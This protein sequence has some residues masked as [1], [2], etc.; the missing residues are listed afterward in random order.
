MVMG[1]GL[2]VTNERKKKKKLWELSNEGQIDNGLWKKIKLK[3][4]THVRSIIQFHNTIT[5]QRKGTS[6][7]TDWLP[8]WSGR[9]LHQLSPC[10]LFWFTVTATARRGK[11]L[12]WLLYDKQTNE[13]SWKDGEPATSLPSLCTTSPSRLDWKIELVC[14]LVTL[15][16]GSFHP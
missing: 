11:L 2:E 13:G 5:Q 6:F 1:E 16:R 9:R 10:L 7:Y 3:G 15:W 4:Q 14:K 12:P 8:P